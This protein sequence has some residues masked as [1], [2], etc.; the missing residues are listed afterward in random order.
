MLIASKPNQFAVG[1]LLALLLIATRGQHFS[2]LDQ[3]PG[4]SWAVFFLAGVYLRPVWI[5]PAFLALAWGLDFTPHLLA[6]ASLTEIASGGRAFCLTPAYL[7]LLPA[8]ASLWLAGRW[9]AGRHRFA[10]GTLL[11]LGGSALAGAL[12]CELF[13][14]GGF[15]LFSGRFADPSLAEFGARLATYFPAYLQSLAFYLG[16]AVVVHTLFGLA[17]GE[18]AAQ[19]TGAAP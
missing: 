7:F 14:S 13:S 8:Y 17:R 9:Y 15:Y 6:G 2:T 11:P 12:A 1:A 16:L 19:R 4:A 5:L 10:W 18:G 3:L